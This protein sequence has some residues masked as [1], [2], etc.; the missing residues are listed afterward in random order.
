MDDPGFRGLFLRRVRERLEVPGALR[1]AAHGEARDH[2][3]EI[4]YGCK[5][6]VD[7]AA[8]VKALYDAMAELRPETGGLAF[9]E[10][11]YVAISGMTT[12]SAERLHS[13]LK[14]IRLLPQQDDRIATHDLAHSIASAG[15]ILPLRGT[16][17]L[18]ELVRRLN[19]ARVTAPAQVPLVV[20]FL[21]AL[22]STVEGPSADRLSAEVMAIREELGLSAYP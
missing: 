17:D 12:L 21:A 8:A 11:C 4:V 15:E 7:Q 14:I 1:V 6:H 9:L 3:L 10:D 16:E 13:V 5:D 20:R 2:I 18:P 19:T 22:A